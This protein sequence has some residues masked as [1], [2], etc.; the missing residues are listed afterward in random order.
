LSCAPWRYPVLNLTFTYD[1]VGNITNLNDCANTGTAKVVSFAY[2]D[3]H[4]LTFA[5]TTAASST[6]FRHSF[7]YDLLGSITLL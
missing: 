4:R 2:D 5:S 6:P 7:A 1:P 3:L